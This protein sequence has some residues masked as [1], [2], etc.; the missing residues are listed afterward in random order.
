MQLNM[1][2]F[3]DTRGH[4]W[5]LAFDYSLARRIKKEAGLDFVNAHDG[6][7]IEAIYRS[8]E[9]L[10]QVLWLLCQEQAAR[11]QIDEEDFG[12]GLAGDALGS[13]I[14]ALQEALVL[15]SRPANRPVLT[16]I[17][18][19]AREAQAA[20]QELVIAKLTS[21]KVTELMRAKARQVS[22]EIDRQLDALIRTPGRSPTSGPRSPESSI[23]AR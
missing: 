14:D 10:V 5:P 20:E 11:E 8:D 13:A 16:Q 9:K 18:A 21:E 12:R 15:F 23:S 4:T 17:L 22:Q 2:E 6:K 1:P 3:T 19:K 7:A